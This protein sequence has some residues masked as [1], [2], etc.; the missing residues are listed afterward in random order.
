MADVSNVK[1][2]WQ[3][4]SM[5]DYEANNA[6]AVNNRLTATRLNAIGQAIKD[7]NGEMATPDYGDL[8]NGATLTL[9]YN[10]GWPPRPTSRTSIIVQ[11][12]S[13]DYQGIPPTAIPGIDFLKVMEYQS[14]PDPDPDPTPV[15]SGNELAVA[16]FNGLTQNEY[17]AGAGDFTA[18]G[19]GATTI[20]AK[21]GSAF[22][23]LMGVRVN[24]GENWRVFEFVETNAANLRVFDFYFRIQSITGNVYLARL[25]DSINNVPRAD[26][27]INGNRTMT[28]RSGTTAS[29]SSGE[30]VQLQTFT[31]YRCEWFVSPTGQ[32][33]R[34][35]DTANSEYVMDFQGTL[36]NALSDTYQFG[37]PSQYPP[38][39][40]IEM[41][42]IRVGDDWLPSYV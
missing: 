2:D 10:G 41:D 29:G 3:N 11:W 15:P 25:R 42:V 21:S 19:L 34:V 18:V 28:C 14:I 4:V 32:R 38:G 33:V 23:G 9:W 26:L 22:E 8:P 35:Y 5:A 27:R 12:C 13:V 1:S 24:E 36:A 20:Q 37:A 31:W 17:P 6:N 39:S 16:A 40:L 7:I 30:D